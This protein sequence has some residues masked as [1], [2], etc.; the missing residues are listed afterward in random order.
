MAS[1]IGPTPPSYP[2]ASIWGPHPKSTANQRD[3][4]AQDVTDSSK[5]INEAVA[6]NQQTISDTNQEGEANVEHLREAYTQQTETEQAKEE[7]TLSKQRLKGYEALRDLKRQQDLELNKV[8]HDGETAVKGQQEYFQNTIYTNQRQGEQTL[9]D[10]KLK[11]NRELEFETSNARADT[12]VVKST[13]QQKLEALKKFQEQQFTQTAAAD[14]AQ[15]QVLVAN[16]QTS[17][18]QENQKFATQFKTAIDI[19]TQ[20]LN[21]LNSTASQ[22]INQIRQ[23]TAQK[24]AAY[25]SRQSDPFYKMMDMKATIHDDGTHFV[26]IANIPQHEQDHVAVAVKGNEL[27]LSGS[28]RNEE[29]LDLGP[30][31]TRGTSSYQSFNESFPLPAPVDRNGLTKEFRGDQVIIR[32]PKA[33]PVMFHDAFQAKAPMP[34]RVRAER[35][36]FPGNLPGTVDPDSQVAANMRK[37][38]DRPLSS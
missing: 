31:R 18:D 23:D 11:Q 30:G 2:G 24:L 17:L 12:E 38:P 20:S 22:Q 7:D 6:R 32:V 25:G 33:D 26:L 21:N 27:L 13:H 14:E 4:T 29:K 1:P 8:H 34:A 28:R 19:D 35:P 5:A 37:K 15:R 3:A 16:S 36:H 9:Q 10:Q